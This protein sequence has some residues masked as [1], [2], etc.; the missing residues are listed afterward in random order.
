[1]GIDIIRS[2]TDNEESK[3]EYVI[4]FQ[5]NNYD[6]LAK[7]ESSIRNEWLKKGREFRS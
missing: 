1:M 2:T 4:I 3:Y 7:W 6:N 5:F